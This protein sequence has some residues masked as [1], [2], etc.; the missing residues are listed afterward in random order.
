[1][2]IKML[3]DAK[4]SSNESGN[5]VRVYKEGEIVDCNQGWLVDLGNV[6][7]GEEL[8]IEVK[9][10]APTETKKAPKKKKTKKTVKK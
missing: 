7:L 8:A 5:Q 2:K 10:D 4:G 3:K 9:V 6:F 1:M